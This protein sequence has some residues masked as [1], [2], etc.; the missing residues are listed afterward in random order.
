MGIDA[1]ALRERIGARLQDAGA[2]VAPG[3]A[4]QLTAFLTLL[5]RWNRHL[6]LTGFRLDDLSDEALDRLIVE[7]VVAARL[8]RSTDHILIDVGSG[9]GSPAIP[10]KMSAPRLQVA[11]IE[12]KARK[13][14]FLREAVRELGLVGIEVVNARFE[15][16]ASSAAAL[17]DLVSLRAVAATPA[18]WAD[19]DRVL[20]HDGRVFWFSSSTDLPAGWVRQAVPAGLR[21]FQFTLVGRERIGS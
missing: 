18:L 7:P 21:S 13:C 12:S 4:D 19:I 17:A 5:A 20:Q 8:I 9:G 10:M 6:N 16:Y 14:A 2:P 11:L 3:V 1:D 15:E